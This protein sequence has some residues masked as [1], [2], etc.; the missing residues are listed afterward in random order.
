MEIGFV[1]TELLDGRFEP[2]EKCLDWESHTDL[3]CL[4]LRRRGHC[5][6]VYVPSIGVSRTKTYTHKLG[7]EV[8]R[9]PAYNHLLAPRALLRPRPYEGGTTTV[10]R[11]LLGP[12]FTLNL[13]SEV[14]K[15]GTQLLHYSSYYSLFFVSA[16]LIAPTTPYVVQYTGGALPQREPAKLLWQLSIIPSLA[17]SKFVLLG[18]YRSEKRSLA[19][20]LGVSSAKQEF[21]NAPILDSSVFYEMDKSKSQA[22]LGFDPRKTNILCVSYIPRPHALEL[23]KNPY[24]MVDM[25]REAID[26]GGEELVVY[27]AG[28]GVGLEEFKEYVRSSGVAGHFRILGRVD[29]PKLP[30][31]YSATDLVWLPIGQ[32][33]LNEGLVTAE[34][35]ACGRPVVAFKRWA[36]DKTE[37]KGGFLLDRDP[38]TG[39]KLLLERVRDPEFLARKGT[40]GKAMA[41]QYSLESAG[42]R[43]EE[44][45]TRV[46]K[47]RPSLPMVSNP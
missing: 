37:Q 39:G 47:V 4:A 11:Q 9:V 31:Y 16:Y 43:L 30:R 33:Q 32:E 27:V 38:A 6:R 3:Y 14:I 7:H 35:F 42:K 17:S 40:E 2:W 22:E 25:V 8:K 18:D 23:A 44:I 12:A 36:T 21:F 13:Q 46:L 26:L 28:W 10:L 1:V 45:Y 34:A 19:S 24:L 29:H 15:D 20:Q 5:S 41:Q